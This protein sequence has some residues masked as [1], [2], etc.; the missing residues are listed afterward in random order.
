MYVGLDSKSS[1]EAEPVGKKKRK[2]YRFLLLMGSRRTPCKSSRV[3][4]RFIIPSFTARLIIFLTA[5]SIHPTNQPA[6][7]PSIHSFF[8]LPSNE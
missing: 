8:F 5:L 4:E 3:V 1:N 2:A 6:S 7:K